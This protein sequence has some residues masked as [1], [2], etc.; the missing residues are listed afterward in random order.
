[1]EALLRTKEKKIKKLTDDSVIPIGEFK[2]F[3]LDQ[4]QA[5]FEDVSHIKRISPEPNSSSQ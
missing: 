2:K 5:S 1:M 4:E 3:K